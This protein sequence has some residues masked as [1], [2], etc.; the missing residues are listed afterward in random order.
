MSAVSALVSV[1]V[2]GF[3][4]VFS[5]SLNKTGGSHKYW[6]SSVVLF[7]QSWASKQLCLC[8]FLSQTERALEEQVQHLFVVINGIYCLIHRDTTFTYWFTGWDILCCW[9]TLL[10]FAGNRTNQ[11]F[12][13]V[14]YSSFPPESTILEIF[15]DLVKFPPFW[16]WKC[17]RLLCA[18]IRY[19]QS[20]WF[21]KLQYKI[22]KECKGWRLCLGLQILWTACRTLRPAKLVSLESW[23]WW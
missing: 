13:G 2:Q 22:K 23:S 6:Q 17:L 15:E 12:L 10:L 14:F 8:Q 18:I 11:E 16:K 5:C 9:W 19:M 20:V 1:L 7:S 4:P 21:V 3:L